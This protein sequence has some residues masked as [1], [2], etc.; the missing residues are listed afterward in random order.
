MWARILSLSLSLSLSP[1]P[2]TQTQTHSQVRIDTCAHAHFSVQSQSEMTSHPKINYAQ[3]TGLHTLCCCCFF[4][5]SVDPHP[6]LSLSLSLSLSLTHTHTHTQVCKDLKYLWQGACTQ[7]KAE[8]LAFMD[9]K[10]VY[11]TILPLIEHMRVTH[12]YFSVQSQSEM[13][14]HPK[15]NYAQSTGLHRLCCCCFFLCS[16]DPHPTFLL[17]PPP[18]PPPSSPHPLCH[19][20][21]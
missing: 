14:S 20:S 11:F 5:C 4:L 13:T 3:S 9:L 1:S 12:T 7:K 15:V 16:V 17:C 19:T 2:N 10:E 21:L 8:E 18:P 6:H